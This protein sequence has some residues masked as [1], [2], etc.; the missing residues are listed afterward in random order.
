[1]T[2]GASNTIY[3]YDAQGHGLSG[4]FGRPVEHLIEVQ[5]AASLPII[6]GFG[7]SRVDD[8]RFRDFVS[9]GSAYSHVSG[10]RNQKDGSFTSLVTA[11]VERLNILD[12]V[13]ADRVV[14]RLS[15]QHPPDH[16]EPHIVFLGSEFENL[17]IS[18]CLVQVDLD[19][20]FFVRSDTY[21][22][23]RKELETNREFRK[24]AEDPYQTGQAQ[25]LSD[26]NGVLLCSLVKDVRMNCPEITRRGHALIV[27]QFGKVFLAEVLAQPGRRTLTMLRLELGSPITGDLTVSGGLINGDTWP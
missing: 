14:A 16:R 18:G 13:T 1:M 2:D 27:P 20:G 9:F 19:Q 22:A 25:K 4:R 8:F 7:N 23:I 10:S 6:G 15:S 5:A 17:R 24:M 26:P 12:M 3:H 11:T 21:E